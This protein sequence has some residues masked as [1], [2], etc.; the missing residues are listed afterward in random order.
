MFWTFSLRILTNLKLYFNCE[1]FLFV[2][3]VKEKQKIA[4]FLKKNFVVFWN[5]MK[6]EFCWKLVFEGLNIHIPSL[7]SR[8]VPQKIW[9]RSVQPFSSLLDTNKQTY[10]QSKY[11][12][13][14]V[15]Y[16]M[17]DFSLFSHNCIIH[18]ANWKKNK[19]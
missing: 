5:L 11:I 3:I 18:E 15:R 8:K 6:I 10:K 16:R 13:N 7:W 14:P 1:H 12:D 19:F 2:N 9:A 4:D 17:I